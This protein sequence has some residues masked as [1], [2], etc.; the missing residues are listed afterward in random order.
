M[1]DID[2]K[3]RCPNCK[4]ESLDISSGVWYCKLCNHHLKDRTE[5]IKEDWISKDSLIIKLKE[6]D[7]NIEELNYFD[8]LNKY[9][10]SKLLKELKDKE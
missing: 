5:I 7:N 9:T 2:I 8:N 10:L 4:G 3:Y 6:I 1:L